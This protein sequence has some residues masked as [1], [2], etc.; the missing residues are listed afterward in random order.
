MPKGKVFMCVVTRNLL[1][2]ELRRK[3][4]I[5]LRSKHLSWITK[6][7]PSRDIDTT[8]SDLRSDQG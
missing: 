3:N 5:T 6:E 2:E 4:S 7:D 1:N 8:T